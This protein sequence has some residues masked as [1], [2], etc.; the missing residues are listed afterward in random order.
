MLLVIPLEL[1]VCYGYWHC[2]QQGLPNAIVN[3]TKHPSKFSWLV[4]TNS[5]NFWCLFYLFL[6]RD[7]GW[8]IKRP[9]Y[10]S[11]VTTAAGNWFMELHASCIFVFNSGES[12]CGLRY[13]ENRFQ[14]TENFCWYLFQR[15]DVEFSVKVKLDWLHRPLKPLWK[16]MS[17]WAIINI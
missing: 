16:E 7:T 5:W 17:L 11:N 10:T 12:F 2:W 15:R 8:A 6:E 13:H 3:M 1:H 4:H 14:K 9:V